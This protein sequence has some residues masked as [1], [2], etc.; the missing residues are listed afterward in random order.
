MSAFSIP[1]PKPVSA[2]ITSII[3]IENVSAIGMLYSCPQLK[4]PIFQATTATHTR[5]FIALFAIRK[6]RNYCYT[7]LPCSTVSIDRKG[8]Y[9]FRVFSQFIVI[10]FVPCFTNGFCCYFTTGVSYYLR[11]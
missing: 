10:D 5:F 6:L 3:T 9:L 2:I 4:C 8:Q 1:I 7:D 11:F